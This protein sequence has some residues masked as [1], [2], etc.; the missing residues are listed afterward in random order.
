[1]MSPQLTAALT[2]FAGLCLVAGWMSGF[3]NRSYV[4][5]LG[6][7][8]LALSGSLWCAGAANEARELGGSA[9]QMSLLA[10]ALLAVSGAAFVIAL[11]AAVQ[12]TRRRLRELREGHAASVEAMLGMLQASREKEE[13]LERE[14]SGET[15]E[16]GQ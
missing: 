15:D 4:G 6:L 10:K 16:E 1:M 3:R 12:E 9:P 5:W 11:V 8:F 7:A 13:E 14:E 2:G